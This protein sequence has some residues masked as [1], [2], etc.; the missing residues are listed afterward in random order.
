MSKRSYIGWLI[1][2]PIACFALIGG[3]QES[4]A[5]SGMAVCQELKPAPKVDPSKPKLPALK[6]ERDS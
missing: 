6:K 1:G 2:L 5:M 4:H 3:Y